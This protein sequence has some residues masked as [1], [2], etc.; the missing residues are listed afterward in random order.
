MLTKQSFRIAIVACIFIQLTCN[1]GAAY[2]EPSIHLT[3][4][5]QVYA[6]SDLET[7]IYFANTVLTA[8]G[9][10]L[11]Y[12]VDCSL[13][14]S[15][16][17]NWSLTPR[18]ADIGS[19]PLTLRVKDSAG[20][21]LEAASTTVNI[22]PADAGVGKEIRLLIVGDSLTHASVYPN[23]IARLLDGPGNPKWQM[24]GTHKPSGALANVAHEGYG[25]W[26][27]AAFNSRFAA[28]ATKPGS[29][30]PFVFLDS[31]GKPALNVARYFDERCSGARPDFIVVKLGINDCFGFNADDAK[32]LDTQID[33]MFDQA[34]KLLA[35]FRQTAPDADIGVCLTTP[36]NSRDE[37]FV[38]NYKDRYPRSGWNR[39]QHRLVER[40]IEQF[41]EREADR[42]FIIPTELNLD[43]VDGYPS[44]NAVHPN[45]IGY[46]QIG[47]TVFAWLKWRLSEE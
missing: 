44:N 28:D 26:T 35:E 14:H 40:Q 7:K 32:V 31:D 23:E 30:S 15:D 33:G 8:P 36:G 29:S 25:G 21:V 1:T 3:L 10:E 18:D 41:G 34:E 37:A 16:A 6:V 9:Q 42:V 22:V 11:A 43:T 38:A 12:E 13:G 2:D 39:I 47:K 4:P 27:W 24:L 45:S 19:V 20:K 5:P 17:L 46:Q